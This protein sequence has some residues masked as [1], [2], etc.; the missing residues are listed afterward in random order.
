MAKQI[1]I[2]GVKLNIP[3]GSTSGNADLTMTYSAE[4]HGCI[5][6]PQLAV[7]GDICKI[8]IVHPQAGV[9]ASYSNNAYISPRAT[10]IEIKAESKDNPNELSTGLIIRTTYVAVDAL[11]RDLIVWFRFKK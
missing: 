7:I 8:E 6:F 11:G 9:V 10:E 3:V 1:F 4:L 2:E 5:L